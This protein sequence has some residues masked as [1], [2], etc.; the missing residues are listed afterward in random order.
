MTGAEILEAVKDR[1]GITGSYQD[2]TLEGYILDVKAFLSDAGV[3]K[4]VIESDAALGA[5][6]RG[7]SDLWNYGA[8]NAEFSTYF[9]QRAIQLCYKKE[10]VGDD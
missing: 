2:K 5:I 10:D 4:D 1:L 6:S 8:G 3:K 7:V 9:M